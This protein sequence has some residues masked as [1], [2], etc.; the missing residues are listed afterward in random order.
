MKRKR[1]DKPVSD[2]VLEYPYLSSV[3]NED[4]NVDNYIESKQ[5]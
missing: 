2:S 4:D 1:N 3:D 5:Y